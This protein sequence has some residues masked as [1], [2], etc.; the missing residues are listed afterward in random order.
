[1]DQLKWTTVVKKIR[2]KL[3]RELA[4]QRELANTTPTPS[5]SEDS[6]G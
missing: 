2:Q 6:D 1:M 5:S 3:K 4:A